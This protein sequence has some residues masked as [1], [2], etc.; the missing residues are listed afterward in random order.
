MEKQIVANRIR[1]FFRT[2]QALHVYK[3]QI[4]M[5]WER[6]QD[7]IYYIE[8]GFIKAYSIGNEGEEFVH[9]VYRSDEVFSLVWAY[10]HMHQEIFYEALDESV[11]FRVPLHRFSAFALSSIAASH[12]LAIQLAQQLHVYTDRIDN[13]EYKKPPQRV[14]YR[15][16]FLAGRFGKRLGQHLLV[17]APL[18][19]QTIAD[20]I[21]LARETVSREMERLE[22]ESIIAYHHH[23]IVVKDT[24]RLI[25]IANSEINIQNWGI[26]QLPLKYIHPGVFSK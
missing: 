21:N 5:G 14:A 19:H 24:T 26:E 3:G 11:M 20:S 23:M 6:D 12:A 13:L 1:D 22:Q 7:Y 25:G 15:L 16:V 18:T 17:N 10:L 4:V 2:G 9:L 8:E